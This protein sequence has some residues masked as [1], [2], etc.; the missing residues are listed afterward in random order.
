ML[1]PQRGVLVYQG[2]FPQQTELL[3]SLQHGPLGL[4]NALGFL[5]ED[6]D[7]P[8]D[9]A[10]ALDGLKFLL[11]VHTLGPLVG[12][13]HFFVV[14]FQFLNVLPLVAVLLLHLPQVLSE[15]SLDVLVLFADVLGVVYL[16][17]F[18]ALGNQ[19]LESAVL[20]SYAMHLFFLGLEQLFVCGFFHTANE[21]TDEN[22]KAIC[23]SQVSEKDLQLIQLGIFFYYYCLF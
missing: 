5:L 15:L 8:F 7:L 20:L 23:S 9:P 13:E 17:F 22:K 1:V 10:S 19:L 18:E 12:V 14:V 16:V 4:P 21:L 6:P 2:L 3:D 11:V